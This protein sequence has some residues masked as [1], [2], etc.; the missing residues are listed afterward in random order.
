MNLRKCINNAIFKQNYSLKLCV[1]FRMPIFLY[2]FRAKSRFSTFPQN[3]SL[4]IAFWMAY[5]CCINL[6]QNLDFLHFLQ[7]WFY[8]IDYW[9]RCFSLLLS[10]ASQQTQF[11]GCRG[12]NIW[13]LNKRKWGSWLMSKKIMMMTKKTKKEEHKVASGGGG[14]PS[15]VSS[16]VRCC[17][18]AKQQKD[19]NSRLQKTFFR[20]KK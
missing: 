19:E 12:K 16:F 8:N 7:K 17:F 1:A 9:R 2:Q 10:S 18:E 20:Q 13:I 14:T 3:H 11:F 5:F 15:L 4:S 6:W